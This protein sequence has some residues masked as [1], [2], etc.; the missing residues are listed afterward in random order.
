MSGSWAQAG[1]PGLC[2]QRS[3]LTWSGVELQGVLVPIANMDH[4]WKHI[5][6]RTENH[7]GDLPK[8]FYSLSQIIMGK[9]FQKIVCPRVCEH[10]W[11]ILPKKKKSPRQITHEFTLINSRKEDCTPALLQSPAVRVLQLLSLCEY[12]CQSDSPG[13]GILI[14]ASGCCLLPCTPHKPW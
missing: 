3:W 13:L 12:H 8:A 5:S 2:L 10:Y 6:L 7:F 11:L 4:T 9:F 14:T 1:V